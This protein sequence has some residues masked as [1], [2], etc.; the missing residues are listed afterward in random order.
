MVSE[1]RR[2]RIGDYLEHHYGALWGN[3]LFGVLL[4]MTGFFGTVLGLPIDI[5]HVAFSAAN[6]GF[7]DL[8]GWF[9][10]AVYLLF[11]LMIG[12]VNLLVSFSLALMVGL[13]ARGLR[14]DDP[15]GM[16]RA[17]VGKLMVAPWEFLFPSSDAASA[18]RA[19][20]KDKS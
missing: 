19:Q 17:L 11:V 6:L 7:A 5:R 16:L 18:E 20:A 1:P 9:D 10:F 13:R 3:F 4:G 8:V 12:G 15:L 2:I 14:I